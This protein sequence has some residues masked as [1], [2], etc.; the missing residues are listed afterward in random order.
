MLEVKRLTKFFGPFSAV[1][2][3]SFAVRPG[4]VLGYLGPNGSGKSTTVKMLVGLLEPSAGEVLF[5]N[6]NIRDD[7]L[8]YKRLVGYVPEDA[9]L[10]TYLTAVEYLQLV[11]ELRGLSAPALA[12]RVDAA[13]KLWG[14]HDSRLAQLSSYSKGM[15]QKVLI[16]AALIGAPRILIL[17]EP[18]TGLDIAS[19]LVLRHLLLELAADGVIVILSSHVLDAIERLC[20]DVV[21]LDR[22][23]VVAHDSV[24]KLRELMKLDSL[25]DVFAKL[26]V[27]QDVRTL[28][29]E[30]ISTL[31]DR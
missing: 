28:A 26:V 10:Y 8:S 18:D 16:S 13:L 4:Q 17:D 3:V 14:L 6:K 12:R 29:K 25:E 11:G 5:D 15:K 20:S 31:N 19:S 30:F 9:S 1:R 27:R 7:L 23:R 22:G 21:I 24:E 2:D